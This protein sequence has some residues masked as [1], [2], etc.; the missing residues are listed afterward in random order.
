MSA[1]PNRDRSDHLQILGI[2]HVQL[3]VPSELIDTARTFFC[4]ILGL[5]EIEKP[6]PLKQRG[7]FW[8]RVGTQELHISPEDGINRSATKAH[9]AFEVTELETVRQVLE[10]AGCDVFDGT[11]IPNC[12]RLETRDPFGNRLEFLQKI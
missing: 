7:G 6:N 8:L 12:R 3:T 1:E 10:Q 2:H 4:Q 11:T 9:L 5:S